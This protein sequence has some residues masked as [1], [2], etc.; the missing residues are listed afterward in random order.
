VGKPASTPTNN[1]VFIYSYT[2]SVSRILLLL[3]IVK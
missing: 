3:Y 1:R 2:A